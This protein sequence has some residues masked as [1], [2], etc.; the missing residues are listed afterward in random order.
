MK[1]D[2]IIHGLLQT[3]HLSTG[4]LFTIQHALIM[5][6]TTPTRTIPLTV[7]LFYFF[8]L[9]AVIVYVIHWITARWSYAFIFMGLLLLIKTSYLT[10][11]GLSDVRIDF[12]AFVLYGIFVSLVIRSNIF[13]DAKWTLAATIIAIFLILTRFIT[14]VY[15]CGL[16]F[17][18]TIYFI[19][20][21]K[22]KLMNAR[23]KHVLCADLILFLIA[24][25]YIWFNKTALFYYYGIGHIIGQEKYIRAL[26]QDIHT[27]MDNILYYPNNI[28][29]F[30][31]GSTLVKHL[32]AIV[33][34]VLFSIGYLLLSQRFKRQPRFYKILS[35][36]LKESIIFLLL[37]VFVPLM[38]LTL[39][40]SKS[41]V[42]G[43]I[44]LIPFLW[45][46]FLLFI[47]FSEQFKMQIQKKGIHSI[48]ITGFAIWVMIAALQFQFNH[49]NH[50]FSKTQQEELNNL[51]NMYLA[52]GDYAQHHQWTKIK[53]SFI[54]IED[55]L[56]RG[57]LQ[58]LYFEQR[59][60]LLDAEPQLGGELFTT[61]RNNLLKLLNNSN[62]VIISEDKKQLTTPYPFE[63]AMTTFY[64]DI[65]S[66]TKNQFK[67]LNNF[68][69]NQTCYEIYVRP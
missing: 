40:Y 2:G 52:I 15:F 32:I 19:F 31:L 61:G 60:I 33:V 49:F 7:N 18:L 14:T 28:L 4:I 30:H 48:F 13:A 65:I 53:I 54:Y 6:L 51:T 39:D 43:S 25:L 37:S 34:F 42:C 27:I 20:I 36:S 12:I 10:V 56:N 57:N 17:L 69:F 5:L 46:V 8:A 24:F 29:H 22:T 38:I 50:R 67:L 26:E 55:F 45:L 16:Y 59:G 44:V 47:V 9:Q 1:G 23:L 68:V 62:V 41:F 58:A 35:L 66:E 21:K 63:Q 3:S 11:G 64:S